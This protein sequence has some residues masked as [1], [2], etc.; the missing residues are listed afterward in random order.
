MIDFA[1][2]NILWYVAFQVHSVLADVN[3]LSDSHTSAVKG[4]NLPKEIII[5]RNG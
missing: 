4:V 3:F 2:S 1:S 5:P